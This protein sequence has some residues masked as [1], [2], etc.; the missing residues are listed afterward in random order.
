MPHS[1]SHF[2]RFWCDLVPKSSIL[3]APWR[4]VGP[5]MASEIAQV[6]QKGSKKT[7]G[8]LTFCGPGKRLA[9]NITFGAFLGTIL[10]DLAWILDE[11]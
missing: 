5:K 10:V 11:F 1:G 6:S 9:S 2:L 7:S 4:P 3:G 8:P